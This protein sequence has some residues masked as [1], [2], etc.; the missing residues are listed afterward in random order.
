MAEKLFTVDGVKIHPRTRSFVV[1]SQDCETLRYSGIDVTLE[2]VLKQRRV[3]FDAEWA[4][5]KGSC[6]PGTFVGKWGYEVVWENSN[7]EAV[8]I[9][10]TIE[11]ITVKLDAYIMSCLYGTIGREWN[12]HT[13]LDQYLD[14]DD[15]KDDEKD[16]E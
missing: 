2:D 14:D 9:P 5:D 7:V 15:E 12:W 1:T 10:H 6:H 8:L 13:P 16:D 11:G 3:M 4:K